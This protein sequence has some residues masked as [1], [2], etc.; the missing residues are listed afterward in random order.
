[1]NLDKAKKLTS[2]TEL[3]QLVSD[4]KQADSIE[5]DTLAFLIQNLCD[6]FCI[7]RAFASRRLNLHRSVIVPV[8][9]YTRGE[10]VVYHTSDIPT[11]IQKNTIQETDLYIKHCVELTLKQQL[12]SKEDLVKHNEILQN[13]C[14]QQPENKTVN[15]MI[16]NCINTEELFGYI[17]LERYEGSEPFSRE[18]F[19]FIQTV[20]EVLATKINDLISETNASNEKKSE[21]PL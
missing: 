2:S 20:F 13:V 11:L 12:F 9:E 1:M 10:S 21:K 17:S 8:M 15:E 18:E 7:D 6:I 4:F 14:Y 3:F 19:F 16:L 5:P